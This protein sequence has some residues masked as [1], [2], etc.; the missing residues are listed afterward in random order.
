MS[1]PTKVGRIKDNDEKESSNRD[2]TIGG[3]IVVE[4]Y[5]PMADAS[6]SSLQARHRICTL[7]FGLE[8]ELKYQS[9]SEASMTPLDMIYDSAIRDDDFYDGTGNL[10]WLAAVCLGHL[11][12]AKVECLQ[13]YLPSF[14]VASPCRICELGCGTGGG[15]IAL[16]LF[17][18]IEHIVE[19]GSNAERSKN[20]FSTPPFHLVFTDNDKDALELCQANCEL[21]GLDPRTYS[22]QKLWWGLN[23]F[24][25]TLSQHS[26]DTVLATDVVYDVKMIRPLLETAHCLLKGDDSHF[27]LCH[28]P[29][30]CLPKCSTVNNVDFEEAYLA[31]EQHIQLQS[32]A[33]GLTLLQ[34]IRPYV[35]LKDR[36]PLSPETAVE[37]EDDNWTKE[38]TIQF[39][40]EAH[41]VVFV[42]RRSSQS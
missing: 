7:R 2:D 20:D 26:F 19:T 40:K 38:L 15:G 37:E 23:N 14:S 17:H 33:A 25:E 11:L 35:V 42:F 28:V 16:L 13:R 30:F 12:A 8:K 21:N 3:S 5:W 31:L 24:P 36:L 41:V 4:E 29:R 27:I 34:M 6:V 1:R 22:H 39:L 32:K 18:C 9:I 10:M